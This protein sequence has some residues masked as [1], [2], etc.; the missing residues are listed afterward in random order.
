[1]EIGRIEGATRTIGESQG[2]LGL[3][4]KDE[5]IDCPVN[6]PNTPRMLTAWMPNEEERAAIA[7]GAP[8]F[9]SIHGRQ[10]PPV[11]LIVGDAPRVEAVFGDA[12][13]KRMEDRRA[14]AVKSLREGKC[15]CHSCIA[16]RREIAYHMVVCG[17]CGNKRC[18]RASNHALVC[19]NSNEPGQAGSIYE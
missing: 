3:P 14:Q 9:L 1:M 17:E 4:I 8:I 15:G 11:M 2:Y 6:G 12:F 19:T 13:F 5:L 18:P 10:H 7:A 16:G